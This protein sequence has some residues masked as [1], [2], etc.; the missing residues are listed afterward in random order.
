MNAKKAKEI[1]EKGISSYEGTSIEYGK[2]KGYL[3]GREDAIKE[4]AEL[5]EMEER[6]FGK[7]G[8]TIHP[9]QFSNSIKALLEQKP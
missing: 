1:I 4:C 6:V 2:A 8:V 3:Q 9:H 7:E 5:I